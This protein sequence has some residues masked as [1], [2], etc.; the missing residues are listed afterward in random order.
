MASGVLTLLIGSESAKTLNKQML[1]RHEKVYQFDMMI[2]FSTDTYDY[3]GK[4][5]YRTGMDSAEDTPTNIENIKTTILNKFGNISYDQDFPMYSAYKIKDKPLWWYKKNNQESMVKIPKKKVT[6][7]QLKVLGIKLKKLADIVEEQNKI[8]ERI[9]D[10]H[11]LRQKEIIEQWNN[12]DLSK[13]YYVITMNA[14]VSNG[15]YI[16]IVCHDMGIEIEKPTIMFNLQRL[17]YFC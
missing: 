3:L 16:R 9:G 1:L 12:Q 2:G 5:I 13:Y 14:C 15:T 10:Q 11:D 8:V 6:I 17:G 7:Y 4:I